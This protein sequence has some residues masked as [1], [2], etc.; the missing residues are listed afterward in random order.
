MKEKKEKEEEEKEEKC[1]GSC[2]SA[3]DVKG[4]FG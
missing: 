4:K 3:Q 1:F 2:G